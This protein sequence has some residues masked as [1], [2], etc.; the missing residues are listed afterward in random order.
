[1]IFFHGLYPYTDTTVLS[2]NVQKSMDQTDGIG[3]LKKSKTE[4]YSSLKPSKLWQNSYAFMRKTP[5]PGSLQPLTD[6]LNSISCSP[7][8]EMKL[9]IY[10]QLT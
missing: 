1:M 6:T 9:H 7:S 2:F 8:Q 4:I 5:K 3:Q 10:M